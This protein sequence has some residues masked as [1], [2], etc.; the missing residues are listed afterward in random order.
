MANPNYASLLAQI[1][2]ETD[3]VAK[4]ALIAECYVFEETPTLE[5]Q[6]LFEYCAFDYI[7]KTPGYENNVFKSY[8]GIYFDNEGN[9]SGIY[10]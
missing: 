4:A 2:A 10:P 7:E 5:E 3:P 8:V 6:E 1:A 9:I